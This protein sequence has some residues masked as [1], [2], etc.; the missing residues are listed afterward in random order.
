M[1]ETQAP[2]A[3]EPSFRAQVESAEK[4]DASQTQQQAPE[5][6]QPAQAT[7]QTPEPEKTVPLKALHEARAL[8]KSEKQARAQAERNFQTLQNQQMELLQYIASQQQPRQPL[9]DKTQDPLGYTIAQIEELKRNQDNL[10]QVTVGQQQQRW[11]QEQAA[12]AEFQFRQTA[13]QANQEFVREQP[14]ANDAINWLKANRVSQYEA[15]GM[16]HQEAQNRMLAE[17]RELVAAAFQRGDNPARVAYDMA[18]A[19]GYT[20]AAVKLKMQADGQGAALP[21]QGG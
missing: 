16:S 5:E 2:S 18:R 10:A 1:A 14:E 19:A 4:A 15:F 12:M 6:G 7:E 8:T 9:P 13:A 17:E 3:P 21:T 20:P 11:Q